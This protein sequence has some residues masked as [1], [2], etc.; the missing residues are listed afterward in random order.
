MGKSS[1]YLSIGDQQRSSSV[2]HSWDGKVNRPGMDLHHQTALLGK[3]IQNLRS[4]KNIKTNIEKQR[5]KYAG[6][7]R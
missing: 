6:K 2:S 7:Y 3:T 5:D 4:A 1:N